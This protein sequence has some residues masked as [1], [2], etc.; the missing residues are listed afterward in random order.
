MKLLTWARNHPKVIQ[1]VPIVSVA[2]LELANLQ[3]LIRMW[4]E[5]TAAGQSVG[6][7]L[8]VNAALWLWLLF[9]LVF[10]REQKFAI[11]GT[12]VGIAMNSFVVLTVLFFRYV[13]PWLHQ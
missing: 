6:G 11:W 4:S 5:W 1:N 7:W 8:S 3:Q 10:N 9:Y 12:V 2:L 13:L